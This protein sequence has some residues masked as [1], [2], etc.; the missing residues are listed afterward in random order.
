[1]PSAFTANAAQYLNRAAFAVNALGTYGVLGR[2]TY[3][4]PGSFNTDLGLHKDFRLTERQKFQF[5]FESFNAFNNVN[6][7]SV[8]PA[9]NNAAYSSATFQQVTAASRDVNN[10]QNPGGR[11]V[12]FVWRVTW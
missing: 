7:T 3:R 9:N 5:R 1:M 8:V 2:N 10:T 12:Q 4:G 11:L 6:F